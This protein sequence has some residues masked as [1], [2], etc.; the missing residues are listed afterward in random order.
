MS[1]SWQAEDLVPE[2]S[3]DEWKSAVTKTPKSVIP[4]GKH[5]VHKDGLI[6]VLKD[7]K[8]VLWTPPSLRERLISLYHEPPCQGH[9]GTQATYALMREN[10]T[11]TNLE[12]DIK[13]FIRQCKLCQEYKDYGK[14]KRSYKTCPIPERCFDE[15]SIDVVGPVPTS[16]SG[17]R[18][19][20]VTQDRLSRWINFAR[21]PNQSAQT[22]SKTFLQ[23][24][25]CTYGPPRKIITDRG[26]NFIS[27]YFEE[28]AKLLGTKLTNTVA[29]RPQANGQNERSHRELHTYLSMYVNRVPPAHWDTLLK[30]AAWVH[31]STVHEALKASPYEIVTGMKPN[32]ARIWLPGQ[33]ETL[34]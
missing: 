14:H 8:E 21:M 13:S 9:R 11:W 7:N 16:S 27:A 25:V 33:Q 4:T 34:N 6:Y 19:V 2:L 18:Y 20:L 29:Y 17:M 22:T 23:E 1:P 28:L 31:N 32:V 12:R 30:L 26:G 5:I 24:W 10:V 15:V 3:P